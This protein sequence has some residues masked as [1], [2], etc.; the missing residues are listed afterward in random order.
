MQSRILAVSAALSLA[1]T[2][3][4][5]G[6]AFAWTPPDTPDRVL[7]GGAAVL[8]VVLTIALRSLL[9]HDT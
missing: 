9:V 2:V 6:A 8:F 1:L 7:W 3:L 5:T 4:A